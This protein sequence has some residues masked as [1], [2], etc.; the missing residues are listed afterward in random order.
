MDLRYLKLA[1]FDPGVIERWEDEW[2]SDLGRKIELH[3]VRDK[4]YALGLD[5]YLWGRDND[6]MA[7]RIVDKFGI[8]VVRIPRCHW[9]ATLSE[10]EWIYQLDA[11]VPPERYG[12]GPPLDEIEKVCGS[13]ESFVN[14]VYKCLI[15][16][17]TAGVI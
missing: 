4:I 8:D 6:D 1:I 9:I 11:N 12:G 5:K 13:G 2:N 17:R 16:S 14:A 7:S 15:N 3:K 10:R